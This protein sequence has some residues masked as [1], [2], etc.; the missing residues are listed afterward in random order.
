[1]KAC[2]RPGRLFFLA[3]WLLAATSAMTQTPG[4][5]T[6]RD[7]VYRADGLPASGTLL[8]SWPAFNT[9]SNQAV[10]AGTLSVNI[11]AEGALSLDLVPNIG[12]T[13]AGTLYRVV[14]KLDDG[15][16]DCLNASLWAKKK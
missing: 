15:T 16:V 5:T 1:M 11:A 10:S 13:S 2:R 12:A 14:Y 7:V 6:I 9:A 3:G 8:I 4:M